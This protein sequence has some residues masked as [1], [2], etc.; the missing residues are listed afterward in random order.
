MKWSDLTRQLLTLARDE[1]LGV[2]GAGDLSAAYL[3]A[4][5]RHVRAQLVPRDG[6]V[7][8]GLEAVP[9]LLDV[10]AERLPGPLEF[11][12]VAGVADG[13]SLTPQ[14][15]VG[16]LAGPL[17]SVLAV[18][19][20]LL[21]LLGRMS[22]VA[23]VTRMYVDRARSANPKV[24]VLDTRKTL[25]G[26]RE[27]DKYSVKVG[28]GTNHRIGLYDAVMLKDNH[29]ADLELGVLRQTLGA[30]LSANQD[31]NA[32]FVEVEVDTLEQFDAI[33]PL[34]MIDVILLDNFSIAELS[35]AV[36]RRDALKRMHRLQLEASGSIRAE[37]IADVAA[38]G[39]DG[40]S[41]GAITH[42]AVQI[43]FGLD[44]VA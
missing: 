24:A 11:E 32:A 39:V 9:L 34:E 18:E 4:P 17:A 28:G 5:D 35:E 19:R 6:G 23:S 29:I 3:D 36:R 38:T 42:S 21:N 15:A 22:G 44:R 41:V 27:L 20:T 16:A 30:L 12:I 43:D 10:F 13:C 14:A 40:I 2:D 8:C 25:P 26:W 37:R 33:A 7:L 1:D 31:T